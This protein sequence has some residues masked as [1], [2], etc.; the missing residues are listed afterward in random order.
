PRIAFRNR[1]AAAI[2]NT[3]LATAQAAMSRTVANAKANV[4][5]S[6]K[7]TNRTPIAMPNRPDSSNATQRSALFRAPRTPQITAK[8]PSTN[9]KAANTMAKPN[10][11]GPGASSASTPSTSSR[12]PRATNQPQFRA[13]SQVSRFGSGSA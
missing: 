11:A 6:G 9:E 12:T 8:M 7:S 13:G 5:T 3:P 10:S 2:S 4:D 1:M